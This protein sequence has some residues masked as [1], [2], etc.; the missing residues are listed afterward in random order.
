MTEQKI[1]SLMIQHLQSATSGLEGIALQFL[2]TWQPAQDLKA[3]E[4]SGVDGFVSVKVLPR[5][6]E[7][8]TIPDGAFQ[9]VLS[10]S[11]RAD[12]DADGQA[13]LTVTDAICACL[14]RL[15]KVV[16]RLCRRFCDCR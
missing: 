5:T 2:G 12:A 7:T 4:S 8:P 15:A 14:H 1:E 16:W 11:M 10:L 3:L 6:Y 9:V 13:Y